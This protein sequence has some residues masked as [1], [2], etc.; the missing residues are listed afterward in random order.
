MPVQTYQT[1]SARCLE[2]YQNPREAFPLR[3]IRLAPN[4]SYSRGQLLRQLTGT[5]TNEVQTIA[6]TG[7]VTGGSFTAAFDGSTTVTIAYNATAAQVQTALE[8]ILGVGNVA[9]AGGALPGTGVTVTFKGEL[10]YQNVPLLTID[11]TAITGGGSI[12]AAETTAGV[13]G[14][15][16]FAK[17]TDSSTQT[18]VAILR[19]DIVT[20]G[21]GN[22]YY[23][24]TVVNGIANSIPARTAEAYDHGTFY[25]PELIGLDATALGQL[26]GRIVE[27][28]LANGVIR[29]G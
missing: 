16:M 14:A 20:D 15:G 23:G 8:S 18:A 13:T 21:K 1:I 24:T 9:C 29:I 19:Y 27:G 28:T 6:K 3:S 5:N 17:L 10:A 26:M 7:T 11:T 2:P 4:T 25:T 22:H 12:G